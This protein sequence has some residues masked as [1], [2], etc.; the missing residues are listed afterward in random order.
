MESIAK[1]TCCKCFKATMVLLNIVLAIVSIVIGS[2]HL[3]G[4][5]GE[6]MIPIYL[7]VDGTIHFAAIAFNQTVPDKNEENSTCA[8]MWYY[9]GTTIQLLIGMFA[10]AWMVMGAIWVFD[11]DL[12]IVDENNNVYCNPIVYYTAVGNVI[13]TLASIGLLFAIVCCYC[14][15]AFTAAFLI[16]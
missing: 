3:H 2:M 12:N 6:R 11:R 7:I 15:C 4:C 13:Y 10:I 5:V 1:S 9:I 14:G 16:E 8:K